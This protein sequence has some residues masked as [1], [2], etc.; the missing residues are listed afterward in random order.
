MVG[1]LTIS[2]I[3]EPEIEVRDDRISAENTWHRLHGVLEKTSVLQDEH[4]D[5]CSFL[6]MSKLQRL[7]QQSC[8]GFVGVE[9]VSAIPGEGRKPLGGRV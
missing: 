9:A 1:G 5:I 3:T 4:D 8:A 7:M 2:V 6:D